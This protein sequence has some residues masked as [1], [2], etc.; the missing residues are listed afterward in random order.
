MYSGFK[1]PFCNKKFSTK[2]TLSDHQATT[3]INSNDSIVLVEVPQY[4]VESVK[5]FIEREKIG[6]KN[7]D[8]NPFINKLDM[9]LGIL[10]L[11]T[12]ETMGKFL[13][14]ILK[15][16]IK[17]GE[18]GLIY[19]LKGT[20]QNISI[21]DF[22]LDLCLKMRH[23]LIRLYNTCKHMPDDISETFDILYPFLK[24]DKDTLT[25]QQ[26]SKLDYYAHTVFSY[27]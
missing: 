24:E 18:G 12:P 22:F 17:H 4:M 27:V 3:C 25:P 23:T 2:R 1:C 9:L 15:G 19:S 7:I 6:V 5:R 16:Y 8:S 11:K 26:M 14:P 13:Y 21:Y 10:D 20:I